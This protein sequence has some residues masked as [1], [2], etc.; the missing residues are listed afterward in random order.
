MLPFVYAKSNRGLPQAAASLKKTVDLSYLGIEQP[1]VNIIVD[2]EGKTNV[3]EPK[4]VQ[5][6]TNNPLE[7]VV[8]LSRGKLDLTGGAVALSHRSLAFS[9]NGDDVRAQLS[10]RA[11]PAGYTGDIHFGK[12]VYRSADGSLVSASLDIPV[13][14]GKDSID[15]RGARLATKDLQINLIASLSHLNSPVI[16]GHV[17]GSVSLAEVQ[18]RI[19]VAMKPCVA[20]APCVAT[21]DLAARIDAE[22]IRIFER[23]FR[24]RSVEA[25]SF[26]NAQRGRQRR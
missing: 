22:S 18:R 17:T 5:K 15:V 12:M 24:R 9:A 21:L 3:P 1:S 23:T 11:A 4:M 6:S 20:G 26:G 8:D 2:G 7:T 14:I 10:Y 25:G 19:N 13:E 16:E